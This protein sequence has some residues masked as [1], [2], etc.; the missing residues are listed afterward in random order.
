MSDTINLLLCT[1]INADRK[2]T[3]DHLICRLDYGKIIMLYSSRLQY[4]DE[5]LQRL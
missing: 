3:A 4:N 1:Y 2:K 5:S